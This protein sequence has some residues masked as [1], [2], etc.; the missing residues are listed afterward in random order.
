[1]KAAAEKTAKP[2]P[3]VQRA[4]SQPFF[5]KAGGRHHSESVPQAKIDPGPAAS[6]LERDADR[7]AEAVMLAAAGTTAAPADVQRT[8]Q[9]GETQRKSR[10]EERLQ[11]AASHVAP[12]VSP[13]IHEAIRE[14]RT[15]GM[16]LESGLRREVEPHLGADFS[17]VRIH[18]DSRAAALSAQLGALAFTSGNHIFFANGQFQPATA[19]GRRL[20]LHELAHTIQQ[21]AVPVRGRS[22]VSSQAEVPASP[23]RAAAP[24]KGPA[25]AVTSSEVVD[26]G[27]G[28]FV[29]SQRVRDEIEGAGRKG[30]AVRVAVKGLAGEGLVKVRLDSAKNYDS[31]S[32]GSMPLLNPWTQRLG[33]MYVNFTIKDGQ[34]TKGFASLKQGG[35]DINDWLEAIRK[36]ADLL[37]GAGL[38][39]GQ[40]PRPVNSFQSGKLT[41]G[42]SDLSVEVGGFLDARLNFMLENAQKPRIDAFA[43]VNVKGIAKGELKLNNAQD[44]LAGEIALAVDFK[45]F[46]GNV[47]VKYLLDGSVS[48]EGKAAYNADRLS[49]EI[50]FVATDLETANAFSKSAI[51]A[52]GGKNKVQ[53]APPP[54]PVPAP[55]PGRKQRALAATGLLAFNLTKWFAGTVNVVVDGK[56]NV[57]V[58]G[59]IAPPGEIELFKQR[60]WDKELIKF[61]A[62][63]YYGIP[64]VGNLNLF[65]NISL[66]ALASLGPAKIYQIEILGTYSTDPEV[67]KSIQISGAINIS[68]YAGLRLRAEGGAGIEI[69]SHDL[70]FG[71]GV[72]ADLG[73][74]AYA[75]ARP[76]IGFREPGD[77]YIS[78]TLEMVAQPMLGL[79]GDFFI[80]LETPWWSPLSDD[81]WTW[82]LFS[83]E[84]PLTDPIGLNAV[85]KD[86]VLG[87]KTVPEIELKKPEFDPSKFMTNMVD[88]TLPNKS[89]GKGDGQGKFN[90]DGTVPKPEVKPKKPEPKAAE[91]K[92]GKKGPPARSGKSATPD[93]KGAKEQQSAR[94]IQA[95][96][97]ELK[98]LEA[99]GPYARPALDTQLTAIR[100]KVNGSDFA[101][102]PKGDKWIVTP[103]AG[104]KSGK[105][106]GIGAIITGELRD[107]GKVTQTITKPVVLSGIQHT[108]EAAIKDGRVGLF[109]ASQREELDKKLARVA[110]EWAGVA[111]PDVR[112]AAQQLET[113]LAS[114]RTREAALAAKF[115][116][117]DDSLERH[118][119]AVDGVNEIARSLVAI[120]DEFGITFHEEQV[121]NAGESRVLGLEA[122]RARGASA[123]PLTIES[124]RPS[125]ERTQFAPGGFLSFPTRKFYAA[126]HL[127]ADTFN[128]SDEPGNLALMSRKTNGKFNSIEAKVRTTLRPKRALQEPRVALRYVVD[129][130][131]PQNGAQ[132]L[133]TWIETKYGQ[134]L[135]KV[136]FVKAGEGILKMMEGQRWNIDYIATLLGVK[137]R[138]EYLDLKIDDKLQWKAAEL[139]LPAGFSVSITVRAAK[140]V[141][142]PGDQKFP[143]HIG[144]AAF[145]S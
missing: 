70:K 32:V 16:P 14:E 115:L 99:K 110:K 11:M 6:L 50:R 125:R 56:G 17:D 61:E 52:A 1:M 69:L 15:G 12:S 58:I 145:P 137:N 55:K 122:G 13:D 68:A 143:N 47:V 142:V 102:Q 134:R 74:K 35:G 27:T 9:P 89:G 71:V 46:T 75:E 84:W 65:A 22:P 94:T 128:G 7:A 72:N 45:A 123:D 59:K 92:P 23:Q 24:A 133:G 136:D 40:L 107:A 87:S 135:P 88:R 82:P 90:D 28:Q 91:A 131:L 78:G 67:Q 105:G 48:V 36:S 42:V 4:P 116:A 31:L 77:F 130:E 144:V 114:V 30:L 111:D 37:G 129:V 140:D 43:A 96:A 57:T 21:G 124:L 60:D 83:K 76:T 80:A 5:A 25:A 44:A 33:G 103:K 54:A 98:A 18:N 119:I 49:G 86:Y 81:R 10:R 138:N 79:S 113:R 109:M 3:V 95:A 104:E 62:K 19:S 101:V 2:Q 112:R 85:V 51:A 117:S 127:V 66:H 26:L 38:K 141:K 106:L 120:A 118:K 8:A 93:P 139:Y 41:L 64:V 121:P 34:V 29:P 63:A 20:L 73:V 100:K 126:G 108:L 132:R 39:V 53:E 97:R